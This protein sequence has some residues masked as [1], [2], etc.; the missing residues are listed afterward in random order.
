[1]EFSIIERARV[2]A[3]LWSSWICVFVGRRRKEALVFCSVSPPVCPDL[4]LVLFYPAVF[5]QAGR[6][7]LVPSLQGIGVG[8]LGWERVRHFDPQSC[9]EY[10]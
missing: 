5:R 6:N 9:L 1:M 3:D 7:G 10:G 2:W 4:P 8:C